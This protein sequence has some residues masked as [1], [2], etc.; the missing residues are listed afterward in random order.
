VTVG[1]VS[2][3]G[4]AVRLDAKP[5]RS[6]RFGRWIHRS[7]ASWRPIVLTVL[8]VSATG[9][10]AG[11]FYFEYRADR[12]TDTSAAREVIKAASEGAVLLL[13]YSPEGLSHDFDNAKSR[14]TGDYKV[15]YQQFTEQIVTP[16]AQRAQLTTTVRVIRA[17]VSEL[18]PNS[19]AVLAFIEQKTSSKDKPEPVKT[20]SS[21]R[22]MLKKVQGSWLIDKLDV[23]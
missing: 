20:S 23:L 19:A 7:L 17:A 10:A 18:H 11:W 14:V 22:I 4:G 15:F 3:I 13:S 6:R 21:L 2:E 5:A 8:L 9:F 1:D 12:Q 16:A